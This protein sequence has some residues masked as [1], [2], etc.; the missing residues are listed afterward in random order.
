M[1]IGSPAFSYVA[2]WPQQNLPHA[3]RVELRN[4]NVVAGVLSSIF[5]AMNSANDSPLSLE[6]VLVTLSEKSFRAIAAKE[7]A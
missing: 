4:K 1:R 3:S 6:R 5:E 7:R 2:H